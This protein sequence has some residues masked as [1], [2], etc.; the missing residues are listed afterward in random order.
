M[1]KKLGGVASILL[2]LF[3]F[4]LDTCI[5][6]SIGALGLWIASVIGATAGAATG[7]QV[8]GFI[9]TGGVMLA[10]AICGIMACAVGIALIL[11]VKFW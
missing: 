2:G 7:I 5:F 9:L 6:K 11:D 4:Y 1:I 3:I 10:V 8:I